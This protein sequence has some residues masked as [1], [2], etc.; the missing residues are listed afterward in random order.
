MEARWDGAPSM[1]AVDGFEICIAHL[2]FRRDTGS[3]DVSASELRIAPRHVDGISAA[4][5]GG[6]ASTS[7]AGLGPTFGPRIGMVGRSV[8]STT[9]F[10]ATR[11]RTFLRANVTELVQCSHITPRAGHSC[12]KPVATMP[13]RKRKRDVVPK[14]DAALSVSPLVAL[15]RSGD[16]SILG[17]IKHELPEVFAAEILPKLDMEATLNLA[18]VNKFYNKTVWSVDGVRSLG[19]KLESAF[20]KLKH[21]LQSA[22][23]SPSDTTKCIYRTDTLGSGTRQLARGQGASGLWGGRGQGCDLSPDLSKYAVWVFGRQFN[24]RRDCS[25]MRR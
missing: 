2:T 9:D 15:L 13:G 20:E 1:G 24:R 5:S 6:V 23:A 14:T 8:R 16:L 25:A 4:A 11:D 17:A 22:R 18:Q 10:I 3:V 19:A 12:N 7:F 21:D